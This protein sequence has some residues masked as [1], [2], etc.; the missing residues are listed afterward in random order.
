M[1][2]RSITDLIADEDREAYLE[3]V[4]KRRVYKY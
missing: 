1:K 4:K 2:S 3:T